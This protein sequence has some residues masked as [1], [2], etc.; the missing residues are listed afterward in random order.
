MKEKQLLNWHSAQL[1]LSSRIDA[2]Y[3]NTQNVRRF[4]KKHLGENFKFTKE[5]MS[6]LKKNTN[7]TLR[8]AITYWKKYNRENLSKY[9]GKP[10]IVG[11]DS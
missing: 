8:E 3:K 4:F 10:K 2:A 9:K 1:T 5:F 11:N 6:Y 7:I